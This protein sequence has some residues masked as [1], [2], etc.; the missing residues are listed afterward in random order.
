MTGGGGREAAR[1]RGNVIISQASLESAFRNKLMY[2]RVLVSSPF[3][4]NDFVCLF[5]SPSFKEGT[6]RHYMFSHF[7]HWFHTAQDILF[8]LEFLIVQVFLIVHMVRTL[9]FR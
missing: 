1:R 7:G 8:A 6:R 5:D 9:F 4:C 2:Q 3:E